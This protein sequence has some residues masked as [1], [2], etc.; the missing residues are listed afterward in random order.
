[1]ERDEQ[2]DLLTEL[3][4]LSTMTLAT[5]GTT[6]MPHAAPV[7]FAAQLFSPS[8]SSL[9][10][11]RFYFF[12]DPSSQ[13]G[14]DFALERRAAAAIYPQCSGWQDIRGLQM[15]GQVLPVAEKADWDNAWQVYLGK[16]PF[17]A[18]MRSIVARNRMYTFLPDWMRLVD[19]RK[20]F[21]FRQEWEIK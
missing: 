2:I 11:L 10:S 6:G 17:V 13:H 3:L 1:M 19:N 20:G 18:G 9:E 14:K 15:H 7:Y 16:F 8:A 21:G 12:S 5:T 4:S